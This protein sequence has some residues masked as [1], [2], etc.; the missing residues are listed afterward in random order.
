MKKINLCLNY[1]I[2][3]ILIVYLIPLIQSQTLVSNSK[4]DINLIID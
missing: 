1:P 3:L 4:N 2:F